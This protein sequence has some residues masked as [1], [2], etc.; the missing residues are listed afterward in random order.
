VQLIDNNI[1][2]PMIVSSKVKINALASIL[3]IVAGGAIAGVSG[4]FLAIP[5]VAIFKVI[6][7]KIES[8]EP[9]GFL[10]GDD[11]PKVMEWKKLKLPAFNA[12]DSSDTIG[13]VNITYTTVASDDSQERSK[14]PSS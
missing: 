8:L 14:P 12:G 2:V 9:W 13:A 10:L 6:F 11:L 3:G 4:M 7:D 1:L 5:L